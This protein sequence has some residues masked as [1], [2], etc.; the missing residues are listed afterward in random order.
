M[1]AGDNGSWPEVSRRI[2]EAMD[3]A[4]EAED[5]DDMIEALHILRSTSTAGSMPEFSL[6]EHGNMQAKI[7]VESLILQAR[8]ALLS[9]HLGQWNDSPRHDASSDSPHGFVTIYEWVHPHLPENNSALR[10]W[11]D[12]LRVAVASDHENWPKAAAWS[13]DLYELC[14]DGDAQEAAGALCNLAVAMSHLGFKATAKRLYAQALSTPELLPSNRAGFDIRFGDYLWSVDDRA[15]AEERYSAAI[16]TYTDLTE[17]TLNDM[18]N[19]VRVYARRADCFLKTSRNADASAD[20]DAAFDLLEISR[21]RGAYQSARSVDAEISDDIAHLIDYLT[22]LPLTRA[23]AKRIAIVLSRLGNSSSAS[24]LRNGALRDG[25]PTAIYHDGPENSARATSQIRAAARWQIFTDG[26][27][28][29][30]LSSDVPVLMTVMSPTS[31]HRMA[32]LT[33]LAGGG[34]GPAVRAWELVA[35]R[36]PAEL[37]LLRALLA[38]PPGTRATEQG[39]WTRPWAPDAMQLLANIMFPLT[40]LS[41]RLDRTEYRSLRIVPTGAMW[42]FP[43]ASIPIAGVPLGVTAP[44]VLAPGRTR[45]TVR[46]STQQWAAHF[47]LSLPTAIDELRETASK[48]RDLGLDLR[49][50]GSLEELKDIGAATP[51]SMLIFAGHGLIGHNEQQLVLAGRQRCD[52]S[53]FQGLATGATVILNAC[54]S[55]YVFDHYGS[56]S[57]QQALEFLV[58]GAHSVLGT[59]GPVSDRRAGEF[60]RECLPPL[61]AGRPLAHAYQEALTRLLAHDPDQP[62][63]SWATYTPI[64]RHTDFSE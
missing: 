23:D 49:L 55:G 25:A 8:R 3:K 19:M 54:W 28:E 64:G 4:S 38:P 36:T 42:Q 63:A 60:L 12:K 34:T 46:P 35:D 1:I 33:L 44:F 20:I 52:A 18:H 24:W 10:F 17:L 21:V 16:Q 47:D 13:Y 45:N 48:A 37:E 5:R 40:D 11:M 53:D 26:E 32:G 39:V 51:V 59:I 41:D 43:Y 61:A 62:L 31:T 56:D 27:A 29:S 2:R 57:S 15:G 30:I 9:L 22:R 50:F 58:A 6:D 14:K 7:P